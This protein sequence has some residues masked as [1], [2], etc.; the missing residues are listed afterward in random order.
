MILLDLLYE[1]YQQNDIIRLLL[2][3][4]G[5]IYG[6]YIRNL[7][8]HK[9]IEETDSVIM[10]ILPNIYKKIIERNLSKYIDEKLVSN[11]YAAK[12]KQKVSYILKKKVNDKFNCIR[13]VEINFVSDIFL[14]SNGVFKNNISNY[15]LLDVNSLAITRS[16][17][18]FIQNEPN[19]NNIEVPN[20]FINLL[21]NI[22]KKI[23]SITST[24]KNMSEIKLICN[25]IDEGWKQKD[26]KIQIKK[27]KN[28]KEFCPICR[29][30][31]NEKNI[32]YRLPCSHYYHKQCWREHVTTGL[33][34]HYSAGNVIFEKCNKSVIIKCPECR[35]D[36][37]FLEVL[38]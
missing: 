11:N 24:V 1:L 33:R 13:I 22:N 27:I 9:Y 34:T 12:I 7:L 32:V 35:K 29:D 28:T 31:L 19:K 21:K 30:V 15:V 8:C 2:K 20:P 3:H 18:T 23:F 10:V 6:P 36:Y 17:I 38:T 14:D 4:D 25:Y 16:G 37:P 5:V 26:N